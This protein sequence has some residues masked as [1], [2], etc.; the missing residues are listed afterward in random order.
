M[1]YQF[2]ERPLRR[3]SALG[4]CLVVFVVFAVIA[5]ILGFILFRGRGVTT[6]SVGAHPTII[7]DSCSD[8]TVFIQAGAEKQVAIE[9][10]GTS[11]YTQDNASNT[12]EFTH[13]NNGLTLTVPPETNLQIDTSEEITVLGIS[14]TIK[15]STNGSRVT[16]EQ[17]TLEGASRI[18]DNG[19]AIVFSGNIAQGS[20]P[21]LSNNGGSIDVTLPASASFH[22]AFTGILGPIA[23]NV[24]GVQTSSENATELKT[25]VGSNPGATKLTLD[26]NDTSVVFNQT[27]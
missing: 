16:L 21:T 6:L 15:L 1:M 22:L 4:G 25:D 26:L 19:G 12:I 2:R 5:G 18:D 14:G 8:G 10:D 9:G 13:C 23:S 7:G 24:P 3:R 17:V 20:S 27:A 11:D